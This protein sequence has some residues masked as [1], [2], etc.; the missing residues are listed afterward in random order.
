MVEKLSVSLPRG[1]NAGKPSLWSDDEKARF[2]EAVKTFGKNFDKITEHVGTKDIEMIKRYCGSQL[3]KY[4]NKPHLPDAQIMVEKLSV[5]LPR[6][7]N[8]GKLSLWSDDEKARFIEAVKT[9]GKN[10]D[11][12]TEHVGT[13]DIEMIKRYCGSQLMK[14]QKK[15]HLPDAEIMVEKL[16]VILPRGRKDTLWT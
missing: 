13:K 11:K 4:Q 3:M 14:Y 7:K 15:P 10:F 8:A 12:I 5:S 16:G 2:I 9:F 6:G 1:K